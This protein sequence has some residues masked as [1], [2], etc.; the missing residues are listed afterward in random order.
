LKAKDE[1]ALAAAWVALLEAMQAHD[2]QAER[3]ASRDGTDDDADIERELRL[4][5]AVSNAKRTVMRMMGMSS[6][7]GAG[8]TRVRARIG[9]A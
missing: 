9:K 4:S 3:Q 6:A 8:V 2:A 5:Q 7:T 1:P